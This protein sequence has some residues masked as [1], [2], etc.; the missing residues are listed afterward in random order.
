LWQRADDDDK[1]PSTSG[2]SCV[3]TVGAVNVKKCSF[4]G[5]G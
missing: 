5:C 2:S 4:F 1:P 3:F